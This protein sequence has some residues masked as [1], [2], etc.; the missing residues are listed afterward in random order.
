M[1]A[2]PEDA[3]AAPT[4][5][6]ATPAAAQTTPEG[7]PARRQEQGCM[8][9]SNTEV[10][11]PDG[12]GDKDRQSSAAHEQEA[13]QAAAAPQVG[14]ALDAFC[15]SDCSMTAAYGVAWLHSAVSQGVRTCMSKLFSGCRDIQCSIWC[16]SRTVAYGVAMS[17]GMRICMSKLFS[18]CRDAASATPIVVPVV[19]KEGN[20]CLGV[21]SQ[22][23]VSSPAAFHCS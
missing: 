9:G 10:K 8:T 22:K 5:A 13:S 1:Q 4:G 21:G 12:M 11:L 15:T 19:A 2:S 20:R 14:I 3:Q 18:G 7:T 23:L 6:Q 16:S 17:Q